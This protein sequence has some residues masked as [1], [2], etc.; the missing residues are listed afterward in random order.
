MSS[1]EEYLSGFEEWLKR[2]EKIQ[3]TKENSSR[4]QT[5]KVGYEL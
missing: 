4:I 1:S 3:D 2:V 5:N